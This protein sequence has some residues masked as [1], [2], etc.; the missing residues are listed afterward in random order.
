[1][2]RRRI[3]SEPATRLLMPL[4]HQTR[5]RSKR[6]AGAVACLLFA[7]AFWGCQSYERRPLEAAGARDAWLARSPNDEPVREFARR[8]AQRS[9][10][11]IAFDPSDGLTLAEGE[12]VALV[13]NPDLRL[14]RLEA[15]V[16]Q[17]SAPYAGLWQ[18]P[19]LGVDMERIVRGADGANPWVAG[20]TIGLTIPL[21]GSLEAA[22]ATADAR[23]RAEL[24]AVLAREWAT[25]AALRELWIEWSASRLRAE[26]GRDLIVRLRAIAALAQRQE[27][28]GTLTRL[29]AR[30]F[31]VELVGR[32]ADQIGLE[33]RERELSLQLRAMMGLSP[34]AALTL[35]PTVTF[36]GPAVDDEASLRSALEASSPE[37]AAVRARYEVAEQSLRTEVRK[38][39]PDLVFGPGYGSDQGDDRVLLG[40]Q[41]PLPLWNRNRRGVAEATA[42]REAARGRFETTY[43]QLA[44][45]LAIAL[46]RSRSGRAQREMVES[47]VVPL[48][49][50]QESDARRI[51]ELGRVDPLL[52]LESLKA[53]HAARVRLIEART[54]EAI[55]AVRLAELIG[56]V[57]A[58]TPA[59]SPTDAESQP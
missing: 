42:Q 19:V 9:A 54:A 8:L 35:E 3:L 12:V 20:G 37:L 18:D 2:A 22:K 10:E 57:S 33:S 55:G 30:L 59:T 58:G 26:I 34:A 7:G 27:Q 25:R 36:A 23:A 47:V 41:L 49:E 29:D 38:Q 14:A 5:S 53:Q 1:M 28:A 31:R 43:E 32:E 46:E 44:S 56:P 11:P 13:F 16:A 45:R 52:L 6:R 50:E 51:A 17:A 24:D 39:Y 15:G 48:A 4:T 40:V 21:S